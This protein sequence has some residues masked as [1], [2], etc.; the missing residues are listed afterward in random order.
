MLPDQYVTRR[1]RLRTH[2]FSIY[3]LHRRINNVQKTIVKASDVGRTL[4]KYHGANHS[5]MNRF[6][7]DVSSVF[8]YASGCSAIAAQQQCWLQGLFKEGHLGRALGV[9]LGLCAGL[10]CE[11]VCDTPPLLQPCSPQF[12]ICLP[13]QVKDAKV[14][15]PEVVVRTFKTACPTCAPNPKF[16]NKQVRRPIESGQPFERVQVRVHLQSWMLL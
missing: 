2:P 3:Q 15:I 6:H 11:L 7:A 14:H 10:C 4:W 1:R 12:H 13:L 8:L 5:G 16:T 9:V